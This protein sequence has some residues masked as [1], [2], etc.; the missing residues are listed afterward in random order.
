MK[1]DLYINIVNGYWVD[2]YENGISMGDDFIDTLENPSAMKEF[3]EDNCRLEHGK[4]VILD[5]LYLDS[6]SLT[7]QF[8]IE[9]SSQSD[10]ISKRDAF[11]SLLYAGSVNIYVPALGDKVYKLIYSGKSATYG[12]TLD[13][14]SCKVSASFTEPNPHDRTFSGLLPLDDLAVKIDD[15]GGVFKNTQ[16]IGIPSGST[17]TMRSLDESEYTWVVSGASSGNG[18]T[19]DKSVTF[20]SGDNDV[21]VVVSR[22]TAQMTLTIEDADH[23]IDLMLLQAQLLGQYPDWELIV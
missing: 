17:I 15:V 21:T 16:T 4:T 9:G 14:C 22:N 3:V 7:L 23:E 11:Y 12:H 1:K 8:V 19:T 6:R 18:T 20:V 10:F 2:A 5:D 13:L